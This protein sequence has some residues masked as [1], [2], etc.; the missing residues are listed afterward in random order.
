MK[1]VFWLDIM[2]LMQMSRLGFKQ[3]RMSTLISHIYVLGRFISFYVYL[4]INSFSQRISKI[5]GNKKF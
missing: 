4:E 2:F 1:A 3:L 5:Y